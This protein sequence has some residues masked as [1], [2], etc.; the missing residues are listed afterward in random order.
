MMYKLKALALVLT[1]SLTSLSTYASESTYDSE[2]FFTP[3]NISTGLSLGLLSGEAKQRGYEPD[4]GHNIIQLNWKYK[5]AVII[6]GN[7]DWDFSPWA[8]LGFDGWTTLTSAPGQMELYGW[9]DDSREQWTDHS[10]HPDTRLRYANEFDLSIKGWILNNK[11]YRFGAVAGYQQSSFNWLSKGG[12]YNYNEGDDTG[13][14]EPGKTVVSYHQKL[15]IPYIG[16]AGLYR[17]KKLEIDGSFKYSSWVRTSGENQDY[18]IDTLSVKSKTDN[19]EYY[20][21]SASAGYYI[22]DNAKVYLQGTW[23][24]LLNKKGNASI[25][26]MGMTYNINDSSGI[27]HTNFITTVGLKYSF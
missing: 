2:S 17:Y 26:N 25:E 3:E 6:K 11:N 10:Y 14:F 8:S 16:L 13:M 19:Q 20:S 21:L 5:N 4:S 1:A 18:I 22:T 7:I 27:A 9:Q 23:N 12:Y 24:R 15:A